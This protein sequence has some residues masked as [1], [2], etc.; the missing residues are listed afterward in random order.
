MIRGAILD[1]DGTILDSMKIWD[2]AG[3]RYLAGLG[4]QAEKDLP[5]VLAAMSVPEAAAY[6]KDRYALHPSPEEITSGIVQTV[7]DFYVQE[8]RLKDGAKEFLESFAERRIPV[9]AATTSEEEYL[10][11]AFR[12]LGI[13][14]AFRRIITGSEAGCGKTEP[15]MYQM[16]A[17]DLGAEPGE[18][19]VAEDALYA[20]ET[21]ARAGFLTAGVYDS[22]SEADQER[23]RAL[24]DVYLSSLT[25]LDRF[26]EFAENA[27]LAEN[28]GPAA[29]S[30]PVR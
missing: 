29:Q 21:A 4:V 20:L 14:D 13:A 2:E 15:R 26:W 22:S 8:V 25:E 19:I 24:S 7:H 27:G 1:I 5:E 3:P 28:A 23:I 12:R 10:R 17:E 6:M 11:P 30:R 16:A 9:I 18:L